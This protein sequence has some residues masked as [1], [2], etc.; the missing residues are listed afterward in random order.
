MSRSAEISKKLKAELQAE[1]PGT[2]FSVR[3]TRSNGWVG[4][5]IDVSWNADLDADGI[6][7]TLAAFQTKTYGIT[8]EG[9]RNYDAA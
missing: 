9:W 7:E 1:F 6:W 5:V 4:Q 8:I 2:R 3:L